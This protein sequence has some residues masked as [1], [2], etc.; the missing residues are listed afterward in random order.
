MHAFD[1]AMGI[2]Q[3]VPPRISFSELDVQLPCDSIYFELSSHSEM[4]SRATFPKPKMKLVDAFQKLFVA[5]SDLPSAVKEDAF[6]CWDMLLLIHCLYTYV[7]RQTVSWPCSVERSVS[8]VLPRRHME[9]PWCTCTHLLT[10]L[11]VANPLLR[12]S[13]SALYA[14][15]NILDPL[16]LA[17]Q[18]WKTIWD[19]IRI[20]LTREQMCHMGFETSADSYWTLTK[21]IVHRFDAKSSSSPR[22]A[23]SASSSVSYPSGA[24]TTVNVGGMQ[25]FVND[26]VMAEPRNGVSDVASGSTPGIA[27][28]MGGTKEEWSMLDFM[29]IDTDC[30]SQ[31]A[32]LRKILKR[33][34]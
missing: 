24:T 13:P 15:S 30:D 1:T 18:N 9:R 10:Q 14:P 7:W 3:N 27:T 11:Q 22:E 12:A 19:E 31:G 16:K 28:A 5:P 25:I 32:H 26:E 17:I 34:R 4:I 20:K 29:P 33:A 23:H 6:N 8:V 21:L 2:F